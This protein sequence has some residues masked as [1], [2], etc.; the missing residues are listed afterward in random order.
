MYIPLFQVYQVPS[1][2]PVPQAE[3]M[4]MVPL[5]VLV[6]QVTRDHKALQDQQDQ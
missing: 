6:T 1:V 3:A 4:V 2:H 5:V